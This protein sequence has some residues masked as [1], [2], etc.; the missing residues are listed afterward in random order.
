LSNAV[1]AKFTL[2]DVRISVGGFPC[3]IKQN[4]SNV[5]S[6]INCSLPLNSD[7]SP[8]LVAGRITP[9]VEIANIGIAGLSSTAK[10]FNVSFRPVSLKRYVSIQLS[11]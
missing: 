9:L 3:T 11:A 7:N 6:F 5:S 8:L 2:A 1:A 10:T 4:I